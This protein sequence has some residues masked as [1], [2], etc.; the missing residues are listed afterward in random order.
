MET[1]TLASYNTL[2]EAMI[3]KGMLEENGIKAFVSDNNNL[4]VPV[5]GGVDLIVYVKDAAK[6]KEL[7]ES[8]HD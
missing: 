5:F 6:A 2:Q 8:H 3:V 1:T 4:Y 7:L